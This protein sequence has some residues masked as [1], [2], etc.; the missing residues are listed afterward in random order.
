MSVPKGLRHCCYRDSKNSSISYDLFI[1][2]IK[3]KEFIRVMFCFKTS[4]LYRT[5]VFMIVPVGCMWPAL[6]ATV[7]PLDVSTRL[8]LPGVY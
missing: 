4:K 8:Y 1:L 7:A 5:T 3:T 6:V 2:R